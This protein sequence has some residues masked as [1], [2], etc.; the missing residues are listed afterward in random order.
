MH[1]HH[2]LID[3]SHMNATAI[4]AT[5]ALMDELDPQQTV[6]IIA[7]HTATR[8]AKAL[9]YNLDAATVGRIAARG[10]VIG[11]ILA[12]RQLGDGREHPRRFSSTFDL[13][14]RH[15]DAIHAVT[16]SYDHV[17]LGSDLDGFIRPAV[18][19]LQS[20]ADL[21]KLEPALRGKYGAAASEAIAHRNVR[22]LLEDL[23]ARQ[24]SPAVP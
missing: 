22:R 1:R 2:V 13:L 7:T 14:C 17:A 9:E 19:G 5:F 15:I 20:A 18:A 10:G 24:A 3:I 11:L 23:W 21:G 12:E 16:G 6:P 8:F 4:D